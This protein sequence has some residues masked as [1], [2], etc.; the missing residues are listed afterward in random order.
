MLAL[1]QFP[2]AERAHAMRGAD[3]YF[4]LG[5]PNDHFTVG[6]A[7]RAGMGITPPTYE[8]IGSE[9]S[10]FQR[11]KIPTGQNLAEPAPAQTD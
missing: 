2:R 8:G 7:A 11:M 1:T 9:G 10:Y 5:W 3:I 6:M 4:N